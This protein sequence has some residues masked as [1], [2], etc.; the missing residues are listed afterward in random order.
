MAGK[1]GTAQEIALQHTVLPFFLSFAKART[2]DDALAAMGSPN[3]GPLKARLGLPASRLGAMIPLKACSQCI[4]DDLVRFGTSYWHVSHQVP[5]VWVCPTHDRPL[6]FSISKRAGHGRFDWSLPSATDLETI[7]LSK[8]DA[9]IWTRRLS[10]VARGAFERGR[11]SSIPTQDVRSTLLA[12][13][14]ARGFASS[15]GR[16]KGARTPQEI[17]AC[18]ST[19]DCCPDVAGLNLRASALTARLHATLKDPGRGHPLSLV[20]LIAFLFDEWPA[21][22]SATGLVL[23]HAPPHPPTER[24]KVPDRSDQLVALVNQGS[25]IRTA[26]SALGISVATAQSWLTRE[27]LAFSRRPSKLRGEMLKV[28]LNGLWSGLGIKE[29]AQECGVAPL[30]IRRLVATTA[31]LKTHRDAERENTQRQQARGAYLMARKVA[32]ALPGV[33]ARSIAAKEYAWL[34]RNDRA[35]LIDA[36]QSTR[37]NCGPRTPRVD[38]S[39][40]D[41]LLAEQCTMAAHRLARKGIAKKVSLA[42]L[43]ELVPPL[44]TQIAHLDRL[45]LTAGTLANIVRR[46]QK[47]TDRMEGTMLA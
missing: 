27:G 16:L 45:P 26:A 39:A 24:N 41:R 46:R 31:G 7:D 2:K 30:T 35:W 36:N 34:Y 3:L 6:G 1:L 28:A 29:V 43:V 21:F 9:A 17:A 25:S 15:T 33:T 14:I 5:G 19:L 4:Q 11:L 20:L 32:I 10:L 38:W 44:R 37:T 12:G 8:G 18:V 40:R 13:L 42:K 23:D 22:E 47:R